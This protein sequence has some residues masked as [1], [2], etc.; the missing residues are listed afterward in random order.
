MKLINRIM[1]HHFASIAILCLL[2]TYACTP[3]ATETV[4]ETP[5]EEVKPVV[6][7]EN[8]KSGP[9][10]PTFNSLPSGKKD[11]ALEAHVIYRDFIKQKKYDEAFEYWKTAYTLAPAADGRRH[12]HYSDGIKIYENYYNTATDPAKKKEY[13]GDV[14]RL[15]DELAA[16]YGDKGYA[17]GR[18]AFDY[19]Y[20]YTD[21][22]SE[23]EKYNL[24]KESMDIDGEKANYFILNPFTALMVNRLIEKKIPMAE[25]QKYA[26]QIM[27]RI[28][29]GLKEC[30]GNECES[31]KIIEGYAPARLEQLEGMK[32]FYDCDYFANKYYAEFEANPTDCDIIVSTIG[33]LKWG[34]CT[35]SDPRLAKAQAAYQ[36]HCKKEPVETKPGRKS[37]RS[38]VQD[39]DYRGA[40]DCY[41]ELKTESADQTKKAKYALYIAKLYYGELK[42]FSKARRYAQEAA[43]LRPNWGAPYILIGKLYA[44]SGPLCGPGRGWDSQIVTWPAIDMWN[45]AKSIDSESATEANKL[46]SRYR[47]YMPSKEDVFQRSL[48]DGDSFKV[49]C[50]IQRTTT[51]RSA[52]N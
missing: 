35:S 8:I 10:C 49:G 11:E 9:D 3:K 5:K 44:S 46:I 31:W 14:M 16:C 42:N 51:I 29:K 4:T 2:F 37:C 40:I 13:L 20:K 41:E 30:K 32:G 27:D 23:D 12:Y 22:A 33:K 1:K 34:G 7:E 50:W 36:T 52:P 15:Y 24:F 6:V 18:K 19:Y 17:S 48:K 21:A 26:K 47:K 39:G 45:K 38:Y 25:G 43:D 28:K